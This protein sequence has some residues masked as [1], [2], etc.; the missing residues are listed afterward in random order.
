MLQELYHTR[1]VSSNT[2]LL[3]DENGFS[4]FGMRSTE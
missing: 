4:E 2:P 1:V 3:F